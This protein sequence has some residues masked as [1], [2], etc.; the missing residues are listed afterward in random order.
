MSM[1]IDLR[2]IIMPAVALRGTT[3][4]PGMVVHFDVTR[5]R[6]RHAIDR[7]MLTDTRV[8]AV[9]Q[10]DPAVM[11]PGPDD[12]CSVGTV[13]NIRQAVK[14][15]KG[16]LRVLANGVQKAYIRGA[17]SEQPI[18]ELE[19]EPEAKTQELLD[20]AMDEAMYRTISSLFREYLAV[21]GK[22][23]K[24]LSAIIL[25]SRDI[26]TLLER[27]SIH[28]P[29]TWKKR[30]RYL[31][32]DT[33]EDR[34][35]VLGAILTNEVQ[36][37]RI[38]KDLQ[39]KLKERVNKNQREYILREQ[40]KMI[41]E[42]LGEDT[43][44]TDGEAF[45]EKLSKLEASPEVKERIGR[46]I[47]RFCRMNPSTPDSN[48]QRGYLETV[49]ELPWDHTTK[50]QDDLA[51]AWKILDEDH[52]GLKDVKERIMEYLAVR[53]LTGGGRS[54]ILCLVGP[55]GTG[56]TSVAR[57]VARA[58]GKEYARVCLGGVRDE[59]QI[60]GHRR[61]YIGALPGDVT[62]ALRQTK[63]SNPLILLDEVDKTGSDYRGDVSAALLEILDPEQNARFMDHF[64]DIPQDLS[65][66]LFIAT[67]NDRQNIPRP[68]LDRMEVV[69]I[70]GYTE[71][72]KEHIARGH[73]IPKQLR[74]N[75]LTDGDLSITD[76]ALRKL[77]NCYT[78]EAGVRNLE[79]LI[80]RL[81]R[82]RARQMFEDRASSG[83][84]TAKSLKDILGREKYSVLMANKEDEIGIARGLAWTSAG[85]DT[86][87]IEV[88]VMPGKGEIIL[89]GQLGDVMKESARA[90]MS[91]IRS[92]AD[93]YGISQDFF[94]EHDLHIHIPE[95]AVP[96]DGPSAGITMATAMLSAIAEKPIRA[97]IG[98][99]GEITLRGRVLPI[100]GL[101]EKLLAARYAHLKEVLVPKENR[102][103]IEE[104]EAEIT[105]GL[106]ITYVGQ[107]Q[108]VLASAF[109]T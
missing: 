99:T 72:E 78:R 90:G 91:Y 44:D 47:D 51:A 29:M 54:P 39:G 10:K 69:E 56:K 106:T 74:E 12:L 109:D 32:A 102:P 75:G 108:E 105:K 71:N 11:V 107:M 103:D 79:R 76:A 55:P 67:A 7:A 61:T 70:P 30:Q 21:G 15:E 95:G 49:F 97:D 18:L 104:M 24:E 87:Q 83:K 16:T 92:V 13:L 9:A 101:K 100:G 65:R 50:D 45:R 64:V 28:M 86:L 68:L 73:L 20:P 33:L 66:V 63:T 8:F 38:Q 2:S 53:H 89:T 37:L 62:A 60:R 93:E 14:T 88:N 3:I 59:A 43:V 42:E 1:E 17:V 57:S 4:L 80:A 25:E 40:L 6:S 84:V 5:E 34:F 31:E 96:K 77:I 52:Y 94:R 22:V 19:I 27:I 26:S 41:R 98:M 23:S 81:C 35:H 85:G 58:L 36:V 46:E 82:K 48:V